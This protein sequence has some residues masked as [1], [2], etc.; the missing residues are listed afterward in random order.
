MGTLM[1]TLILWAA[2]NA[3]CADVVVTLGGGSDDARLVRWGNV[4]D[5]LPLRALESEMFM[6][7]GP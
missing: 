5:N 7:Y 4:T 2:R 6:P 3:G 1:A